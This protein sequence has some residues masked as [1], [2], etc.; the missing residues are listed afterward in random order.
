MPASCIHDDAKSRM[1]DNKSIGKV[2][3]ALCDDIVWQFLV[4][5][6]SV[7]VC[8][9]ATTVVSPSTEAGKPAPPVHRLLH[10]SRMTRS[11]DITRVPG[12]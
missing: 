5:Y 9:M 8:S 1:N 12:V 6:L 2:C 11:C 3:F 10:F 7:C 4:P